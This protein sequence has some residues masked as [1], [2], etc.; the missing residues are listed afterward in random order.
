MQ[1]H[2]D[3]G[4]PVQGKEPMKIIWTVSTASGGLLGRATQENFV[5][6]RSLNAAWGHVAN[7]VAATAV[8]GIEQVLDGA[9]GGRVTGKDAYTPPPPPANLP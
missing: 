4:L 2:V 5:S 1:G 9:R 6:S 3:I 8:D 7:L